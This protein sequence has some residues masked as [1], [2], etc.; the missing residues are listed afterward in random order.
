MVRARA[1]KVSLLRPDDLPDG[2]DPAKDVRPI[3]WEAVLHLSRRLE[4]HGIES[5]G[6]LMRQMA[7][8]LDLNGVKELAY[9]LYSVCDRKRRQGSALMF[10]SLVTSW[11]DIVE[12]ARTLPATIDSQ[13]TFD[14]TD[15]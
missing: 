1:G 15:E 6:Q 7:S 9:L 10:N 11:P 5:A 2:Y 12:V 3:M 13:M 14:Y 8:V 4:Q